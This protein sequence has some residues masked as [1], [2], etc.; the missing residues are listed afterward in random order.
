V[1][2]YF[3]VLLGWVSFVGCGEAPPEL[4][5]VT[6]MIVS[7]L[8]SSQSAQTAVYDDSLRVPRCRIAGSSC[9]SGTLLGSG[10]SFE[11]EINAPN[12]INDSCSDG[13]LNWAGGG[14]L[15]SLSVATLD[16]T[17]ITG[18]KEVLISA[19]IRKHIFGSSYV[20]L[21]HA[22]DASNPDWV[23]LATLYT[24]GWGEQTLSTG[25]TLP[26][27][28]HQAIRGRVGNSRSACLPDLYTDHDDLVF[29][30]GDTAPPVVS[31]IAP[32]EGAVV[33]LAI[34]MTASASDDSGVARV[35]FFGDGILV[36]TVTEEPYTFVWTTSAGVH[37]VS[38]K[39]YDEE[40]NVSETLPRS[41]EASSAPFVWFVAPEPNA[42]STDT[43]HVVADASDD[44]AI[45]KVQ[46]LIGEDLKA[47]DTTPPY[48]ALLEASGTT[49][50]IARA[51]DDEGNTT[52]AMLTVRVDGAPPQVSILHPLHYSQ[53]ARGP[54]DPRDRGRRRGSATRGVLL[55]RLPDR[56]GYQRA[57]QRRVGHSDRAPEDARHLACP[58]VRLRR[59]VHGVQ[60]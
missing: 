49:T 29:A 56:V 40:G 36:G 28:S 37:F 8:V 19:T 34:T 27:G 4:S 13:E 52:D 42:F 59:T 7:G 31:L 57:L 18:R 47:T 16:G 2:R 15:Q 33:P 26:P 54:R 3:F 1:S 14:T 53:P 43:V 55:R 24:S 32:L 17:P 6:P 39:A 48:E 46:F 11:P 9:S 38:A 60:H 35:E 41:V 50:I 30:L 21:F 44:T 22:S 12:T 20:T 23:Y 51:F 5:V 10:S 58:R 25:Y 45:T